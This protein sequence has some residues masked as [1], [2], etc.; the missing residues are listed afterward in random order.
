MKVRIVMNRFPR[1]LGSMALVCCLTQTSVAD[2]PTREDGWVSTEDTALG[3]TTHT[4]T[5]TIHPAAE[6]LPALKYRLLPDEFDLQDGNAALYYLKAMG[7]LEQA[8]AREKLNE[9]YKQAVADSKSKELELDQQAPYSY[10]EMRPS[11]LPTAQ[12]KEYLNLL[13]FQP[14]F[15]EQGRKLRSF[16]MDRNMKQVDDPI[17]YLLPEIQS[18]RELARVQRVRSRLAIQEGRIDD[19]IQIL[20]QQLA[21]AK[22]LGNDH[23]YVS[24]LVGIAIQ[25]IAWTDA[26]YLLE[27]S[28]APNLYWAYASLPKPLVSFHASHAFERQFLFE[29]IKELRSVDENV[30]PAGYW[31]HFLDRFAQQAKGLGNEGMGLELSGDLELDRIRLTAYIAAAYP[32][33]ARFLVESCGLTS[34]QV[35]AYPTA[36]VVFLAIKYYYEQSRDEYFKWNYVEPHSVFRSLQRT[37]ELQEKRSERI[38]LAAALPDTFLPAYGA[39]IAAQTRMQQQIA[40]VQA[41]EAIRMYAAMH[42]G[43]LPHELSLAPVPVPNDPVTGMPFNYEQVGDTAVLTGNVVSRI[44]YRLILKMDKSQ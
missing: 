30:Q 32:G 13:S 25:S 37:M 28:K 26:L 31:Q 33:A 1:L 35:E 15:L 14:Y 9:M 5:M 6:P 3:A 40:L 44:R 34:D 43:K 17:G 39:L 4:R 10:Q 2:G 18:M 24:A 36:Q 8:G 41:I 38:G 27:H 11:E 20:G 42:E 21:M 12:V 22:H 19:A 29:Q 7:F 23:F 16:S